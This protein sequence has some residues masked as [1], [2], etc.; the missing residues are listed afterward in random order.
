MNEKRILFLHNQFPSGGAER[1]TIDIV[2]YI[3]AYGYSSYVLAADV[4]NAQL[5]NITTLELPDKENVMSKVNADAIIDALNKLCVDIFV[6]PIQTLTYL[7]YIRENTN[8]KIVFA[9]HS[10]P[11]WE[12]TCALYYKKKQCRDSIFKRLKWLFL[13]YPKTVWFK[14]YHKRVLNT[15]QRIYQQ[16]D[17]YT[18]LCDGY[19]QALIDK[20]KLSFTENKFH[21]I[22]NS[23]RGVETVNL[24]KKK[25]IL[26][27]GR[28]NYEDKR[29]DRLVDI[30]EMVYKEAPD[31]ELILVGDGPDKPFFQ[32][33]ARE[34]Q[35]Q[36]ITFVGHS[37]C[38]GKYYQDASILCLTSNFEGWP[39]CL[40]EAQANGVI[41]MAFD[42]V[43]GI[44]EIIS[45]SGENGILVPSFHL[46]EF[47]RELLMLL[48][49][50]E[51][52]QRMRSQVIRKSKE[53]SPEI[54][55][56]KWLNLFN[57]FNN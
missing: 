2:D 36:R 42:C 48:N 5:P 23:E 9:L 8:C 57:S 24:T 13:I 22:P 34:K 14:R 21:V 7:D 53:Y 27:V 26:F 43:S 55:G 47:A 49:D 31:W 25:Q 29:V 10:A 41:P 4:R 39:L 56:R 50:P 44:C 40:T 54:V 19:K 33:R 15:Y 38:V 6:L 12:I 11:F 45:P 18:V 52:L 35:L 17:A 16:V 32:Q 3:S 28:M 20:M 30:W 46:R 37:D 1:V 51:R